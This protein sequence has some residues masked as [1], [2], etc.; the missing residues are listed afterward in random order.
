ML[1]IVFFYVHGATPHNKPDSRLFEVRDFIQ[2]S[3]VVMVHIM[4]LKNI[5]CGA[6]C[7]VKSLEGVEWVR[8]PN[9]VAA[10]L[11]FVVGFVDSSCT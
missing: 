4:R 2:N 9:G 8:K 10:S 1:P 3:T 6:Q 5:V 7:G 11:E